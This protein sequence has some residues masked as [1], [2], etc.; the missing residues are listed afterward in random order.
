MRDFAAAGEPAVT[1]ATAK[2]WNMLNLLNRRAIPLP[3]ETPFPL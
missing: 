2:P 1:S 3:R